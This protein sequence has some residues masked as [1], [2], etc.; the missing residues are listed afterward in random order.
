MKSI[1]NNNYSEIVKKANHN[2]KLHENKIFTSKLKYDLSNSMNIDRFNFDS[3]N[4]S[5]TKIK[6]N[7]EEIEYLIDFRLINYNIFNNIYIPNLIVDKTKIFVSLN[8]IIKLNDKLEIINENKLIIPPILKYLDKYKTF[9]I[10]NNNNIIIG[11]EDMRIFNYNEKIMVIGTA[12][13]IKGEIRVVCGEYQY[14][15]NELININ[16]IKNTFNEQDIEKNWVYF[17]NNSNELNVI[18]KWYPLQICEIKNNNL[19]LIKNVI[20]PKYFIRARGSTCG[21]KHNDNNWFIVHFNENGN[22]YHFFA[23]FDLNMNL[24]KYSEKFK[25]DNYKIEFCIGLEFIDDNIIICYS[26]NDNKSIMAIYR[27]SRLN[28]LI[29]F[30]N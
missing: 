14:E 26:T 17:I 2:N 30:S 16:F 18:Y 10:K 20:L 23:V 29:W 7:N 24:I 8:K 9:V 22:Y 4:F 11:I 12:Q 28:E 3:G 21:I 25:F 15:T 19:Y 6:N 1:I 27:P 13:N 5:I